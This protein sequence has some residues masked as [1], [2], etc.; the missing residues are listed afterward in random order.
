MCNMQEDDD[1]LDHINKVKALANP[2]ACLEVFMRDK[3]IV[4]SLLKSL[5]VSYE[6]LIT[7]SKTMPMNEL[8]LDYVTVRLIHEILKRKKES[9]SEDAAMVL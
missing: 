9:K 8:L 5:P 1:L 4:M 7:A 6:Y 3:D 2:F